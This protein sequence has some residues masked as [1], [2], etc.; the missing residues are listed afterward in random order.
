MGTLSDS[1]LG[2]TQEKALKTPL[3]APSENSLSG[4]I[5]GDDSP[6]FELAVQEGAKRNPT[7]AV[8]VINLKNSTGMPEDVVERNADEIT[9]KARQNHIDPQKFAKANPGV[10]RWM[11][12]S[13][14]H[15]AVGYEDLTGLSYLERQIRNI[16]DQFNQGRRTVELSDI[17][18]SAFLGKATP[19]QRKRQK[20]LESQQA[21]SSDYGITG[22]FEGIPGAIANQLP[23]MASTI[24]GQ[25]KGAVTGGAGGAAVGATGALI[26][27]Q[28][29]PQAALPEEVV[30]VPG[31]ALA[32]GGKGALVGWRYGAGIQAARQEAALAYLDY[33]KLTDNQGRPIDTN[34]AKGAAAIVGAVNGCRIVTGKQIGRAH[35]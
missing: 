15:A 1:I 8:T 4:F 12:Q 2:K 34:V 11:A 13:P 6:S 25:I 33:G 3:N 21:Q 5:S 29:G 32:L 28:L 17:G 16:K 7:Q 19:Q 23:I 20:E 22:F 14:N 9:Q 31:A 18:E 26:G 10:S 24:G 35:V 30:T 27:G